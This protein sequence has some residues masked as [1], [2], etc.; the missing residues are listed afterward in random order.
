MF[1]TLVT[2]RRRVVDFNT[3]HHRISELENRGR[4]DE[5]KAISEVRE[6]LKGKIIVGYGVAEQLEN[7]CLK[8]VQVL[9]V[10]ELSTA[11][12]IGNK[13]KTTPQVNI[14]LKYSQ[15]LDIFKVKVRKNDLITFSEAETVWEIY[16]QIGDKFERS[17]LPKD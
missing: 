17:H 13:N 4:L 7:L 12:A 1:N 16:K 14:D 15:L 11:L 8:I 2:P 3:S 9:G 5:Y 6:I 10:R